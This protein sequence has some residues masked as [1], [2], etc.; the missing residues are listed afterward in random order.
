MA[1]RFF[2]RTWI[3]LITVIQWMLVLAL[4]RVRMCSF[5]CNDFR[6]I[7]FL[8]NVLPCTAHPTLVSHHVPYSLESA[9]PIPSV[10]GTRPARSVQPMLSGCQCILYANL[11]SKNYCFS[12]FR[13]DI[14]ISQNV[15][16]VVWRLDLGLAYRLA[17]VISK[18]VVRVGLPLVGN[19]LGTTPTA[20]LF[21]GGVSVG[22]LG[23]G[24]S[25]VKLECSSLFSSS[26]SISDSQPRIL[27]Q[28][29]EEQVPQR[30][31]N[32]GIVE[33]RLDIPSP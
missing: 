16:L 31:M 10:R 25:W 7:D 19:S 9:W 32:R 21:S 5:N 2:L 17:L 29:Q 12:V 13:R 28:F 33:R 18:V 27:K 23:T 14:M 3:M 6:L 26:S 30:E 24:W 22:A 1:N 4:Y 15:F 11:D 8:L 20:L